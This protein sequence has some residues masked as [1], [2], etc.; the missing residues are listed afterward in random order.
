MNKLNINSIADINRIAAT[1]RHMGNTQWSELMIDCE[2][3]DY[4]AKLASF[5]RTER[6]DAFAHK[7][8]GA[9]DDVFA[10][11]L[12]LGEAWIICEDMAFKW[13]KTARLTSAQSSWAVASRLINLTLAD[14][15]V[16]AEQLYG[17]E[18]FGCDIETDMAGAV[19]V[20]FGCRTDAEV[21]EDEDGKI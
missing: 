2:D 19:F 10:R 4:C 8:A 14:F 15:G 3:A 7:G 5:I 13:E 9:G 6:A 21:S 12:T 11:N 16:G 18:V 1:A 20:I 17:Q